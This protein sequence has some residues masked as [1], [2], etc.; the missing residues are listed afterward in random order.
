MSNFALL[1]TATMSTKSLG[2]LPV[3][4]PVDELPNPLPRTKL[5]LEGNG[6]GTEGRDVM[7]FQIAKGCGYRFII[8]GRGKVGSQFSFL[9]RKW[10]EMENS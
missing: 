3:N 8:V 5:L 7:S 9:Q 1:S 6:N 4:Y 10:T 2:I